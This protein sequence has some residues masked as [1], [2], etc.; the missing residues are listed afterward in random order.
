MLRALACFDV[1]AEEP[2]RTF[3]LTPKA[4]WLRSDVPHSL[5]VAAE[6]VG[7]D[8]LWQPWGDLLHTVTTGEPAFD[9]IYGEA[10]WTGS[11]VTRCP[12]RGST[13]SWMQSRSQKHKQS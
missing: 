6:A 7:E 12:R 13:S 1:F 2:G 9:H 4:E 8:W 10:T 3:R 5:R 11:T